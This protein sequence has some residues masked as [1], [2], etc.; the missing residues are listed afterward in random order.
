[1]SRAPARRRR[2]SCASGAGSVR[3]PVLDHLAVTLVAG[4]KGQD[5]D[6][7]G[8]GL[9]GASDAGCDAN[10]VEALDRDDVIVELHAPGARE[11]DVDLLRRNVSVTEALTL[12]RID[13]MV[14]QARALGREV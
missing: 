6:S 1:M 9:E 2:V 5:F 11:H 3:P 7:V 8:P 14:A 10:R 13:S 4:A 12:A